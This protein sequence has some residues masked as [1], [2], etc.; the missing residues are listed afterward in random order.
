VVKNCWAAVMTLPCIEAGALPNSLSPMVAFGGAVMEQSC[1]KAKLHECSI[2]LTHGNLTK[3]TAALKRT[4]S[5][6]QKG[7]QHRQLKAPLLI[8]N[9]VRKLFFQPC[10]LL[11]EGFDGVLEFQHIGRLGARWQ[12]TRWRD[13]LLV[14]VNHHEVI[15]SSRTKIRWSG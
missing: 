2:L 4:T 13:L 3:Q 9:H 7:N 1:L 15:P 8:S 11:L 6:N 5:Q 12:G 14:K 10:V